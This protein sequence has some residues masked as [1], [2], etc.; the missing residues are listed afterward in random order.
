MFLLQKIKSTFIVA[1]LFLAIT[2]L[3]ASCKNKP[4]N[5]KVSQD[6][7]LQE[8]LS[9]FSDMC[10]FSIISKDQN[11]TAMLSSNVSG[12]NIRNL[13]LSEI[14]NLLLAERNINYEFDGDVLKISS[15]GTKTFKIDYVTSVREGT[16]ITSASVDSAPI[17][18]GKERNSQNTSNADN[19]IKTTEKFDFW[20]KLK[21]EI[22]AILNNGPESIK[23]PDPIIN[24]SAGLI[25]VTGTNSQIKRVEEYLETLQKRLQKQVMIDV[26]IIS[27][28]L[29]NAYSEGINWKKFELGINSHLN[30]DEKKPSGFTWKAGEHTGVKNSHHD[31]GIWTFDGNV[32]FNIDGVINFLETRGKTKVISSPKV[33]TLNNQPALVTV[34]DTINYRVQE[35]TSG[36]ESSKVSTTYKQYSIF[37][38]ILLNLLPEI[39]DNDEITLRINPSLSDFKYAKD[40]ERQDE[41]REIA[42][43]TKQKKLST[44]V[45]VKSGETIILG[46][47]IG[48]TKGKNQNKI[49]LLGDLPLLGNLFS[50]KVDSI[51][52]TELIFI[53][54]PRVIE[55]NQSIDKSAEDFGFSKSIYKY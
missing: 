29:A 35:E 36:T 39:S 1:A 15:L 37:V 34:G 9:Q 14:F 8:I 44:V 42:P 46:G 41:A 18:V 30:N 28:E 47:L 55:P 38:G 13:T 11:A 21:D 5:L 20:S 49:P 31:R 48:Q 50:S 52:S 6:V 2:N 25:T 53:V 33:T 40:S 12:I 24:Q 16:A 19:S 10:S 51:S 4:F 22:K 23:S 26:N 27:V 7:S 3:Y 54:T 17:E 45:R 43:D 32:N